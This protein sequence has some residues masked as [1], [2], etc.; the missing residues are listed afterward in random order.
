M[1]ETFAAV[2]LIASAVTGFV[3]FVKSVLVQFSFFTALDEQ[4]QSLVLQLVAFV[5]GVFSAFAFEVNAL[6]S[7]PAF[8]DAPYALGVIFTG[9]VAATGSEGISAIL[10]LI[11]LRGGQAAERQARAYSADAGRTTHNDYAPFL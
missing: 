2:S 1:L 5:A 7:V 9:L 6:A 10:A 3:L 11:G 4:A 8:A